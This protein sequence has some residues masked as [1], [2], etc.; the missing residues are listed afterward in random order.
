MATSTT[1]DW[2]GDST[3][4]LVSIGTRK[5][6]L[7]AQGPPRLLGQPV[8]VVEAGIGDDHRTWTAV[9]ALISKH[10][11]VYTYDRAGANNSR[12]YPGPDPR[13]ASA[14][15]ADL[16]SLLAAAEVPGPYVIACHSY[17]GLIAREFLALR[18]E[19]V[20]GMVF[21]DTNSENTRREVPLPMEA[22]GAVAKGLDYYQIVGL[23]RDH[24]LD[25]G[26]WKSIKGDSGA[27][28]QEHHGEEISFRELREKRQFER[29]AM[30]DRP[31]VVIRGDTPRDFRA[32]SDVAV[33]KGNG[34]EEDREKMLRFV[35][36]L[37]EKDE[38]LQRE[39]LLL[40]SRSRFVQ[41]EK[42]GHNVQITEPELVA[43]EI[44]KVLKE[45]RG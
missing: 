39:Q 26:L 14:M 8:V 32:F 37:D 35:E 30:G 16:S 13:T 4:S 7:R 9:S 44:E 11:R 19:E 41:A 2:N 42:S 6:F 18:G 23:D 43:A 33:E 12:S 25:P 27:S 1:I 31:V 21:V 38:G 40:S 24:K 29:R 36:A 34:S 3:S 5:L 10:S 15:A 17:G 20:V 22:F 45:I 28:E